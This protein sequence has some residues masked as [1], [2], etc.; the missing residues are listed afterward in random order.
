MI[1]KG[2]RPWLFAQRQ[3]QHWLHTGCLLKAGDRYRLRG[4]NFY[5]IHGHLAD[6]LFRCRWIIQHFGNK[7]AMGFHKNFMFGLELSQVTSDFLNR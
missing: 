2:P 6:K 4:V 5:P 1:S 3:T 7:S